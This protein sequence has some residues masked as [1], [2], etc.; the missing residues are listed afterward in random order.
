[1]RDRGA[2]QNLSFRH[3]IRARAKLYLSDASLKLTQLKSRWAHAPHVTLV[4]FGHFLS[5][6]H[7]D[8]RALVR[9][10]V[11]QLVLKLLARP[12]RGPLITTGC[13]CHYNYRPV[14]PNV[15]H[16]YTDLGRSRHGSQ[17]PQRG[18]ENSL[19]V[20]TVTS[21]IQRR[22]S[23]LLWI[24]IARCAQM[25]RKLWPHE[26]VIRGFRSNLSCARIPR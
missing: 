9:T 11:F 6:S 5:P 18:F 13:N 7:V 26:T 21:R 23:Q 3:F 15:F 10:P 22:T 12:K 8:V 19:F 1:M 4:S 24:T 20:V 17:Y 25:D 16:Q 14:V 2:R